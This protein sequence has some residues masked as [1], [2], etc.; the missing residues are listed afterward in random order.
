MKYLLTLL[1]VIML[2]SCASTPESKAT[3]RLAVRVLVAEAIYAKDTC[4]RSTKAL[5]LVKD[6]RSIFGDRTVSL[7]ALEGELRTLF[8]DKG[9]NPVTSEALLE[10]VRN[11]VE[12]QLAKTDV[13]PEI[14]TTLNEFADIVYSVAMTAQSECN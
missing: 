8:H 7:Y 13:D 14:L 5:S 3:Q 10:I 1:S 2:T 12:I 9:V 6:A 11:M 4:N